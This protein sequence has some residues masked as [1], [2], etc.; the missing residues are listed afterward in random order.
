MI[1]E[2]SSLIKRYSGRLVL[3]GATLRFAGP[4]VLVV[5]GENGA[6]KS[7]LLALIAGVLAPD[8][9]RIFI[10][11]RDLGRE[12]ERALA[13]LGYAPDRLDLPP[14][15][16]TLELLSLVTIL[17]GARPPADDLVERLGAR[18][19][20]GD[21]LGALSLG[22]R[23]RAAL[24]AALAG[25]PA[26]LVLDEPTNGLDPGGLEMLVSLLR[27]RTALGRSAIVATHDAAFAD[28]VADA[29]VE[30]RGGQIHE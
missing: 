6:G 14:E 15:L 5:R 9:G 26:L 24:L 4:G 29:R 11:G 7:T 30:L 23:R 10:G 22:Q 21:R 13:G 8:G 2:T 16:T 28:L 18:S 17:K 19:F 12:R 25:D 27:E 1:L 3:D 20:W